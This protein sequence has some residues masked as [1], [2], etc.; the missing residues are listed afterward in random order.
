MEAEAAAWLKLRSPDAAAAELLAVA[1]NGDAGE[2]ML[3][4]ATARKLGVAAETA[5]RDSL[6]QPELRPY[7]K[8]ALTEIAG[9]EPEGSVLPELEPDVAD[10]AWLVTDV[11]AALC[12]APDEL[13]AQISEAIPPGQEQHVF[14]A[15]SRSPHPD[16]AAVLS[17]IGRHHP[18]RRIAKAARGSAHRARTRPKP[19]P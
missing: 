7:A 8:I 5:W 13:P 16:A 9:G 15:I 11:L 6:A 19:V 3:A 14:E 17:L 10:V 4:V 18:D 12:D 1:A 2:R